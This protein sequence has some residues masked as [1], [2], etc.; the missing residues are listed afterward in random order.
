VTSNVSTTLTQVELASFTPRQC[1]IGIDDTQGIADTGATSIFIKEGT[2]CRNMQPASKPLTVNLPDGRQVKSSHTCK[3]LIPCL[4]R[5]LTGHIAPNLAIASLFGIQPLCN[6]GC[7]VIFHQDKVEV[8]YKNKIILTGPQNISTKLW[9]L[10]INKHLNARLSP[11]SLQPAV[12]TQPEYAAFTHSV[13][14]R[15]K[16]VQF[17]HQSLGNPRISTLLKAVRRGFLDGCP[18]ISKKLI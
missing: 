6:A 15:M 8:W 3:V 13:R 9:T 4:P 7:T 14:T 11:T 2:P 17:A 16:A 1:D 5:P 12:H 18:I 10:P